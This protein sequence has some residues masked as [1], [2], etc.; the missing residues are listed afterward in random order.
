MPCD[1]P[2]VFDVRIVAPAELDL[3]DVEK[4]YRSAGWIEPGADASFIAPMLEHSFA[5]SAAFHGERTVGLMRALSDGVS[6]AYLLDLVI[7]PQFRRRGLARR[8][9]AALQAFI[10]AHGI[11]WTVCVGAPG[12]EEF[13]RRIAGAD[14]MNGYTPYRLRRSRT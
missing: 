10:D 12:T 6:D 7:D 4:L 14:V 9:L 2:E 5:I 1:G 3:T 13:Y 8:V 11:D